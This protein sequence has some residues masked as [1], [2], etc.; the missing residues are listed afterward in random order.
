MSVQTKAAVRAASSLLVFTQSSASIPKLL[1]LK[2]APTARFMPNTW[3]F[4]GGVLEGGDEAFPLSVSALNLSQAL[5]DWSQWGFDH[6]EAALASLGAALREAS[7]EAGLIW[8]ELS[9]DIDEIK[10]VDRWLTP[11][12]LKIRFDTYFWAVSLRSEPEINVDQAE[13]VDSQWW[14]LDELCQAYEQGA[15]ELPAPTFCLITELASLLRED[16]PRPSTATSIIRAFNQSPHAQAICPVLKRGQELRLHLP[17]D[18]IYAELRGETPEL[19]QRV[20]WSSAPHYL[21]QVITEAGPR[22]RRIAEPEAS[23]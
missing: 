3:V 8:G 16:D 22:W 20:F 21:E 18:P 5:S 17:G 23:T 12:Q 1:L 6:R 14:R 11:E 15:L 10:C 2:R 4:P 19:T 9:A 13:I 7:E